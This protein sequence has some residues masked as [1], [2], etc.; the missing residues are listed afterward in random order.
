M[1]WVSIDALGQHW[2][3][4]RVNASIAGDSAVEIETSNVAAF[5][6]DMGSGGCPLDLARKLVVAIDGQKITA[7]GPFSDRSWTVHFRKT[8]SQWS[9]ADGAPQAG[10]HKRHGLQGPIDDAFLD[11]F[12]FVS[13]TGSPMVPRSLNG[14]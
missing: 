13:P 14:L 1:K 6:L 3:R 5:T 2:E 8:G 12:L 11:S 10:L 4:A 7:P 9:L